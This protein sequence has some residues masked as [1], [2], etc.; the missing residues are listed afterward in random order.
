[1]KFG[2][3]DHVDDSGLDQ[4][5]HYETRLKLV[6]AMD[7]LGFDSYHTAEHH[8]TTLGF[9]PS[10]SV[11]LSAVAQRTKRLKF[12]PLVYLPALYHPMRLAEEICM[13]DQ[14]SRGRLQVGVGSGAVWIEQKIY[15]V[16]PATVPE[17]FVEAREII[18]QALTCDEVNFK[19]KHYSV[20]GFPMLLKPYQKPRPPLWYG[21]SSVNSAIWCAEHRANVVSMMGGEIAR[22]PFDKYKE[23]WD[24]L[25][26]AD[27]D[28]PVM[29][30]NR[31][32][33]VADTDAEAMRIA[34]AA[35]AKWRNSFSWLWD[36]KGIAFPFPYP[37]TFEAQVAAGFGVAGSPRTVRDVL[38]RQAEEVGA[39]AVI[40]HMVFGSIAYE[41][42]QRS[43]ELFATEVM[44][45][46]AKEP[47]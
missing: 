41:D 42:A 23:E 35:F 18:L 12:G 43:L 8:G 19:G 44:P 28:L 26:R 46:L 7:R 34:K 45:A 31:H 13:L 11:F 4:A 40:G 30:I 22:R 2:V 39:N 6:E 9:A 3:F 47:A 14:M 37:E 38:A 27:G 21:L 25:G 15:D 5:D 24:R 36:L 33:V 10:P 20:D 1:M 16:D 32:I 29:G 17:R